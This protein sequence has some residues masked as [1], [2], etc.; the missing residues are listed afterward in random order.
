MV[1]YT[2]LIPGKK[3]KLGDINVGKFIKRND[4]ILTFLNSEFGERTEN[5]IDAEEDEDD[6]IEIKRA[7]S[8]RPK[9]R[10]KG[11]KRRKTRK[12]KR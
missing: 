8:V 1:R 5:E 11:G 7:K 4:K 6:F 2:E 3:Y 9:S 12:Q 10:K